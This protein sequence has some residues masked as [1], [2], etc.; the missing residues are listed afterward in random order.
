MVIVLIRPINT[1]GHQTNENWE[2]RLP[3][4]IQQNG[5]VKTAIALY[6]GKDTRNEL[7]QI[8]LE[9]LKPHSGIETYSTTL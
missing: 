3:Q 8:L 5:R 6:D 7:T 9:N 1:I 4:H 2:D